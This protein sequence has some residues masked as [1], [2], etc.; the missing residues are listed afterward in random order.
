M[1][2][3]LYSVYTPTPS[4]VCCRYSIEESSGWSTGGFAARA[5]V[6]GESYSAA[7]GGEQAGLDHGGNRQ[8][9]AHD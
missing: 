2:F 3:P 4:F 1:I 9:G 7:D 5:R 8:R 6:C